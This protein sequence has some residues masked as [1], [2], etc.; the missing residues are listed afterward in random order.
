[1]RV[2]SAVPDKTQSCSSLALVT[3]SRESSML[4]KSFTL[5]DGFT[6]EMLQERGDKT[7]DDDNLDR[8]MTHATEIV[9]TETPVSVHTAPVVNPSYDGG[10]DISSAADPMGEVSIA[11]SLLKEPILTQQSVNPV[12]EVFL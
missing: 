6:Q 2:L 5:G 12:V 11:L 3:D 4:N 8:C 1:M 10:S 9:A 7:E